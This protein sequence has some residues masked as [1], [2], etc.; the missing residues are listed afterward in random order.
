MTWKSINPRARIDVSHLARLVDH[1]ENERFDDV[2]LSVLQEKGP[3]AEMNGFLYGP[4]QQD[5]RPVAWCGRPQGTANRV[6][7]YAR[8]YHKL[9]PTLHSLPRSAEPGQT[10]MEVLSPGSIGDAAYRQLCFDTPS[11]SQKVSVAYADDG[12]EWTILNVYLSGDAAGQD[13]VHRLAAFGALLGPFLRRRGRDGEGRSSTGLE[14]ADSR[15]RK[16]LQRRFPSLTQRETQVCALT[17]IG[18][19][20][21]EIATT[22]GIGAGTVITYRRRAYERLGVSSAASLVAEI[23]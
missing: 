8:S 4:D 2:L 7:R 1:L 22:L 6:D 20:S 15:V 23:L 16:R 13:A 17:M 19:T 9:D 12:G 5:P 14:Y 10:L 11:F 3:A 18:K 21:G